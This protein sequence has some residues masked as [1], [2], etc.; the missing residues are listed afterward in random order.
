M[1]GIDFAQ[2]TNVVTPAQWDRIDADG[3]GDFV[4][5][6]VGDLNRAKRNQQVESALRAGKRPEGYIYLHMGSAENQM[7]EA[8]ENL[9]REGYD[10]PFLWPDIEETLGYTQAQVVRSL[11]TCVAI[12]VAAGFDRATKQGIYTGGWFWPGATGNSREFSDMALWT[13]FFNTTKDANGNDV[14]HDDWPIDF[15]W[16]TPYGGWAGLPRATRRDTRQYRGTYNLHGVNVDLNWRDDRWRGANDDMSTPEAL[17][18]AAR[19]M[20]REQLGELNN[21]LQ[22]APL[23]LV[24]APSKDAVPTL[25]ARKDAGV[26]PPYNREGDITRGLFDHYLLSIDDEQ[27][28][29]EAVKRYTREV[30]RGVTLNV[31]EGDGE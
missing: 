1:R 3:F 10:C 25:Y 18:K 30:L 15:D 29:E 5:I 21:I 7:T 26:V 11:E 9:Q 12:G 31:P 2:Y 17:L 19:A 4:I 6:A 16:F 13:A 8:I 28:Y 22:Q 23:S 14:W 20:N 27:E 24:G